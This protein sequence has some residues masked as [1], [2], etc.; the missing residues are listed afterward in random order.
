MK[1]LRIF[2]VSFA[3]VAAVAQA[4]RP[5]PTESEYLRETSRGTLVNDGGVFFVLIF[6]LIKEPPAGY[7]LRFSF[8][9]PEDERSPIVEPGLLK[10]EGSEILVESAAFGLHAEQSRV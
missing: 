3:I 1:C 10:V 6:E 4:S 2:L 7:H 5:V 9:N 8:E